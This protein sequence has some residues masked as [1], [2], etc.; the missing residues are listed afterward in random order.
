MIGRK[1]VPP[2]LVSIAEMV[3]KPLTR[4]KVYR[5]ITSALAGDEQSNGFRNILVE[6]GHDHVI[7]R[8]KEYLG[9]DPNVTGGTE[10]SPIDQPEYVFYIKNILDDTLLRNAM[11]YFCPPFSNKERLIRCMVDYCW[12]FIEYRFPA[13]LSHLESTTA[14]SK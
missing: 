12:A 3:A 7:K 2:R 5:V 10:A 6:Q 11:V 8:V 14:A 4:D 1:Y 13:H 9:A